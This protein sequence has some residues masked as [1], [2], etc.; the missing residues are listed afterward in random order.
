MKC[1][2]KWIC[3]KAPESLHWQTLG[4]KEDVD[5]HRKEK[6]HL[7]WDV[8]EGSLLGMKSSTY[9]WPNLWRICG[10]K[11]STVTVDELLEIALSTKSVES[12]E[13]RFP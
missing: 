10:E 3:T 4:E 1:C 13:F 7:F 11:K 5:W 8:T 9:G 12:M 2:V 6:N